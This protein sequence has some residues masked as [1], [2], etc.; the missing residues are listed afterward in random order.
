MVDIGNRSHLLSLTVEQYF[1]CR[2]Q[3]QLLIIFCANNNKSAASTLARIEQEIDKGKKQII[4]GGSD[5]MET[6][7]SSGSST[8]FRSFYVFFL[9]WLM[10]GVRPVLMNPSSLTWDSVHAANCCCQFFSIWHFALITL[11]P[12]VFNKRVNYFYPTIYSNFLV[13]YLFYYK[14]EYVIYRYFISV[15][16]FV[17]FKYISLLFIFYPLYCLHLILLHLNISAYLLVFTLIFFLFLSAKCITLKIGLKQG[18]CTY[19]LA[20]IHANI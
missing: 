6:A 9:Y 3:N 15:L 8:C 13:I 18:T 16:I 17:Q 7:V 12:R 1:C 20:S 11:R 2:Q 19:L 10:G 14:F 4:W 5:E